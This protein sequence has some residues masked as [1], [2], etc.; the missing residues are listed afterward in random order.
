MTAAKI[1]ITLPPEQLALVKLAVRDGRADSV[2]GYIAR[3]V[4]EQ[5]REESLRALL[6]DLSRQH[7]APGRKARTWARRVLAKRRA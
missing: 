6:D 7:G 2:S 5:A 3:A 4:A 1:A